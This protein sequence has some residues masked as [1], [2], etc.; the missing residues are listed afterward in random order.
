MR[1]VRARKRGETVPWPESVPC[2]DCAGVGHRLGA[3]PKPQD[4]AVYYC[5]T[6]KGSGRTLPVRVEHQERVA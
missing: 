6:C 2:R 4:V 5:D 1:R 3:N